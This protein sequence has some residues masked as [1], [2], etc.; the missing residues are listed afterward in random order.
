MTGCHEMPIP[1]STDLPSWVWP[2]AA[3]VHIPFCAHKCGYCDFASLAGFDHLADRYLSALEREMTMTLGQPKVVETIF[4]GGGTPTRLDSQ[5][6]VRLVAMIGR[7]LPL[8]EGGEWTVEANPG[9]LDHEKVDILR[10]AGVNR[11][12]LGAQ[13]FRPAL[14]S[15]L[16]RNHAPE[17]VERAVELVRPRFPRWSLDLIFGIPG[18]TLADCEADIEAALE[19]GPSH[20]SCYGL[21]YE[22]GTNL[23]KQWQA[24]Q[25]VP[26]DEETER[27]MYAAVIDRL[28]RAGLTMYEISN[29]AR[30]GHESRHNLVY[31]ANDAYFGVGLGAASYVEGVRSVN[32][33]ELA[34]YLRR[35][36]AGEPATGPTE[37]LN[38]EAR[39]RETA[40]LML[41]RTVLGIDRDDYRLRTGY[42]LDGL[43]GPELSRF[44]GQGL[45]EDDGQR[46][47]FSREGRFLAD[48][49][50]CE[51]V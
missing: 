1:L 7:W 51:L 19:L 25:V 9:T 31:W 8:A 20:L 4:V 41:R 34:A 43:L 3:Y 40:M 16:E 49:V 17:E 2:R 45:L 11:V 24:G 36:E 13:S 26:V 28:E 27:A 38:A 22:K 18:S 37:T 48:R 30:P 33:R 6:L 50:L 23:W 46:L 14:L 12:S 42:S 29:Y 39:A 44:V 5:Q 32:T 15:A 35:I 21:V 47:R 10:E